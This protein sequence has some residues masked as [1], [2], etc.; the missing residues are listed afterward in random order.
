MAKDIQAVR[1]MIT[2]L[3]G[4]TALVTGG[5]R[6]QGSTEAHLL[7]ACGANVLIGDVLEAEGEAFVAQLVKEGLNVRFLKMDVSNPDHWDNAVQTLGDWTGRLDILVNNA[8]IINRT[9]ISAT[10][11]E[12]WNRLLS[13]NLTGSFLGIQKCV[14]LMKQSGGGSIINISSNTAFSGHYDPA[15]TS[16]K[17]ALRGLTRSAAMEYATDNIRVNAVCPGLIVTELNRH[18]PHLQPNIQ[19]TPLKRSGTEEEVA[20]LVLWLAS[21]AS[22][23]VTGEDILIDGGFIAGG[24]RKVAELTGILP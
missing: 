18:S 9:L 14:G 2:D 13:I 15:Y 17:W 1:N 11:L 22:A 12:K 4:K 10:T 20:Q 16:S 23:F 21:D 19:Q 6:G 7:A 3:S 5:A 24:Y 8:G